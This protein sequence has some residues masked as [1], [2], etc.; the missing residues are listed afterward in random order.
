[1]DRLIEVLKETDALLEGHFLLS[2]GKHSNK[3]VQCAK[4]LRFP[5]KSEEILSIVKEKVKDLD[6]DI[7]VGPAMGGV[8]VAYELGRQLKKEAIFTERVDGEMNLRRGFEIKNGDKVII[9]ED[10]ITT[11][12]STK[13]VIDLIEGL[14]GIVVGATCIVDRRGEDVEIGVPVYSAL[15]IDIKTYDEENCP[16]CKGN[17]PAEKPGSRDLNKK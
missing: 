13:E 12:K 9:S 10:V 5:D 1:M 7:V 15:K 17:I 11:G 16:M 6:F 8:I 4:V 2:S 14:G 3:Y